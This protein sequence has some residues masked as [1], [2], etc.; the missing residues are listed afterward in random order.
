MQES[1]LNYDSREFKKHFDNTLNVWG[2]K[3]GYL[4]QL[5]YKMRFEMSITNI[6]KQV[7]KIILS[8]P[9]IKYL[10]NHKKVKGKVVDLASPC[11]PKGIFQ[12]M[13]RDNK[14]LAKVVE[15]ENTVYTKGAHGMSYVFVILSFF[16]E[17]TSKRWRYRRKK[18]K[19]EQKAKK[20]EHIIKGKEE[21]RKQVNMFIGSLPSSIKTKLV[22][23]FYAKKN[24]LF[25]ANIRTD[26]FETIFRENS[27]V[28]AEAMF[29]TAC[30]E[31]GDGLAV[32]CK[33][34]KH[35]NRKKVAVKSSF[36]TVYPERKFNEEFKKVSGLI[37]YLLP[38]GAE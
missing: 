3:F 21:L 8:E 14:E 5:G 32:Q 28:I 18:L 23:S 20:A 1:K 17:K 15:T 13:G 19:E 7:V 4:D 2:K 37:F 10:I 30:E 22:A 29:K 24:Q 12:M 34:L 25:I 16:Y 26:F 11:F 38:E 9:A 36:Q 27:F 33:V 31:I 6:E 35:R